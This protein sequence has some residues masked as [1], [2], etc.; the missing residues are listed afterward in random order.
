MMVALVMGAEVEVE[1]VTF[2]R[3][4]RMVLKIPKYRIA[5]VAIA[6]YF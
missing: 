4:K 5:T 2:E 1:D 3:G 6:L